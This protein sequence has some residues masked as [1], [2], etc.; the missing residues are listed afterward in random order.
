MYLHAITLRSGLEPKSSLSRLTAALKLHA[1]AMTTPRL[2]RGWLELLNSHPSLREL[3]NVQPRL[4]HK[5]YRPW[6]SKRL[7]QRRRLAALGDHYRFIVQ[8]GLGDAVL[9]AARGGLRLAS[10]A[11]KSGA[12]YTIDLRAIVPMEREGE[13]VLQLMCQGTLVYSLAFSF[14]QEGQLRQLGIGCVQGPQCGAGLELAREATRD[15]HG[16]RPKNLLVRLAGQLG[17]AWGCEHL[18]L[19]GNRNRTVCVKSVRKGKVKA[20]YDSLWQELGASRRPDGDWQMGCAP[21]QAPD[22][23]EVPSK[24]RA[25]MRRR[26]ELM[27]QVNFAVLSSLGR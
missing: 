21:L 18:V 4:I 3:A 12:H 8:E 1:R 16:L 15:L 14:V 10:F 27:T 7:C 19:V 13:L 25:E 5:I 11:G 6:L 24:K 9:Q 22:L 26:Y 20:D 2:T 23:E 17:H